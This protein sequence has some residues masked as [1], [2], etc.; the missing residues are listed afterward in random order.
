MA[1]SAV[2]SVAKYLGGLLLEETKFLGGVVDQI[3][4]IRQEM[5]QMQCFLRDADSRQHESE[6]V[7]N[8]V[9][10]IRDL[11]YIAEDI[12]ESYILKAKYTS[13]FNPQKYIRLHQVGNVLR[14]RSDSAIRKKEEEKKG[15]KQRRIEGKTI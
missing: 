4:N 12:I 11:A 1:E 8:L 15:G 9:A 2:S 13:S 6:S 7:R 3:Y 10:D 5:V 14:T